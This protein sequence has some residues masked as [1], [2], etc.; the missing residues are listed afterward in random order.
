MLINKNDSKIYYLIDSVNVFNAEENKLFNCIA[1]KKITKT[2]FHEPQ[3]VLCSRK[4]NE[5]QELLGNF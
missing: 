2:T 4:T 5:N 3:D 1:D